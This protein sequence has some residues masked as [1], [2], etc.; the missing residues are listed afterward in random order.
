VGQVKGRWDLA[1]KSFDGL[2]DLQTYSDEQL[3]G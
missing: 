1:G 3:A 2:G